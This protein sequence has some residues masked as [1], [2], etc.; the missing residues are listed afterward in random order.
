M[1][2]FSTIKHS[3]HSLLQGLQVGSVRHRLIRPS[4]TFCLHHSANLTNAF[5]TR[6]HQST[7]DSRVR[8]VSVHHPVSGGNLSS[9]NHRHPLLGNRL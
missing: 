7:M 4:G 1:A 3:P 9:Y 6:L 8:F 2:R 5:I